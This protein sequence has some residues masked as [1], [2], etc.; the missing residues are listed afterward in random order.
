LR[1]DTHVNNVADIK[2][3]GSDPRLTRAHCAKGHPYSEDNLRVV[4]SGSR[5]GHRV[6]RECHR[7]A[8]RKRRDAKKAAVA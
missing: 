1:Y 7:E 8:E 2:K 5:K 3:H 4:A 6:C